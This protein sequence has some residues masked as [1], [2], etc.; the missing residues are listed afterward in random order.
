MWPGNPDMA[1]ETTWP[2]TG[3]IN[4][5]PK[6]VD[7][8]NGDFHL[9]KDSPCIDAGDNSALALHATDIDGDDR[10]IDDP[11]V[12]DTGN[13]TPPIVDMGAY[14]F[15]LGGG[16]TS[17]T[18]DDGLPDEWELQFFSDLDE[19]GSSDSDGDGLI[20]YYEYFIGT[21]PN[22]PDS[23]GDSLN[24]GLELNILGTDPTQVDTDSDGILDGDEDNDGDGLTNAE[25]VQCNS[26]PLDSTSKCVKFF[27]WLMLLLD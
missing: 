17:D 13:G 4:A 21:N 14:E 1:G 25:E 5:D 12:A 15:S 19:V 8:N 24:D 23:D 16:G 2:G 20:N 11:A 7:G 26:D 27:P 9:L 18:D 22:N 10:R 3:N 6:L